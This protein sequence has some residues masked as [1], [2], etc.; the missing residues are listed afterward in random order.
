MLCDSKILSMPNLKL[1][2]FSLTPNE[3]A[4]YLNCSTLFDLSNGTKV[5]VVLFI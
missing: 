1:T 5:L 3:F 2:F 4:L